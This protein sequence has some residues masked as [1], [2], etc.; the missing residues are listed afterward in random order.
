MEQ[1]TPICGSG[2]PWQ[3]RLRAGVSR[4]LAIALSIL[5]A[6]AALYVIAAFVFMPV[7]QFVYG[8]RSDEASSAAIL[9]AT[10][11]A[12]YLLSP[13]DG[14]LWL[15]G[16]P[17]WAERVSAPL[18]VE[19][20][21][22]SQLSGLGVF[23]RISGAVICLY[24]FRAIARVAFGLSQSKLSI[25]I[26]G[27]TLFALFIAML[28]A[29]PAELFIPILHSSWRGLFEE[30]GSL[31]YVLA[32]KLSGLIPIFGTIPA[33]MLIAVGVRRLRRSSDWNTSNSASADAPDYCSFAPSA[34]GS[35]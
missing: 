29:N 35:A 34:D 23:A 20:Q 11:G 25:W 12:Y 24:L 7:Y 6:L 15:L 16:H 31:D 26:L 4:I 9:T 21:V 8:G 3:P 33:L 18:F 13:L 5:L 28:I 22:G 14:F 10:A 32:P 27:C 19:G 2:M 17:D 1:E 30:A